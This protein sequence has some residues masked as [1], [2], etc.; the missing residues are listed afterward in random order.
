MSKGEHEQESTVDI[1]KLQGLANRVVALREENHRRGHPLEEGSW[2]DS[3]VLVS[4]NR[5]WSMDLTSATT[6]EGRDEDA[7]YRIDYEKY[8]NEEGRLPEGKYMVTWLRGKPDT[9]RAVRIIEGSYDELDIE[10]GNNE[11]EDEPGLLREIRNRLM[12]R[13]FDETRI[14]KGLGVGRYLLRKK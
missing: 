9:L 7:G 5:A 3:S 2:G 1:D 10:E 13:I 4:R 12:D 6:R 8:Y 11:Y 14:K